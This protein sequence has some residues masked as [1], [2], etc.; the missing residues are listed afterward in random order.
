MKQYTMA[1]A[2]ITTPPT[3]SNCVY[4]AYE[5]IHLALTRVNALS[6]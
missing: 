5:I 1:V 3:D 4:L 2:N 6:R